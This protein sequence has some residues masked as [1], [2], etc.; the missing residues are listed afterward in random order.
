MKRAALRLHAHRFALG[1]LCAIDRVPRE[2]NEFQVR[3]LHTVGNQVMSVLES[4]RMMLE[5]CTKVRYARLY[6][7]TASDL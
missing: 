2:L 1:T 6:P 3:M 7:P 4:R 5:V